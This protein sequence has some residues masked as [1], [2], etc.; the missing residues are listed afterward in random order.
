[1]ERLNSKVFLL[2]FTFDLISNVQLVTPQHINS[3]RV[4]YSEE[5]EA[6]ALVKVRD[7]IQPFTILFWSIN[8]TCWW[9]TVPPWDLGGVPL[10]GLHENGHILNPMAPRPGSG[11]GESQGETNQCKV[12][13]ELQKTN[14]NFK[15]KLSPCFHQSHKWRKQNR[16]DSIL[17]EDFSDIIKQCPFDLGGRDK[18]GLPS[19]PTNFNYYSSMSIFFY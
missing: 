4:A 13:V 10:W 16:V 7:R 2:V 15:L 12:R 14:E 8:L 3:T 1:M 6:V 5:A 17:K 19:K 9:C 11:C 18:K